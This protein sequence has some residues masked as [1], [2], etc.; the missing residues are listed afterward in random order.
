MSNETP[1]IMEYRAL[2]TELEATKA[3][4]AESRKQV[5]E[6]SEL[7]TLRECSVKIDQRVNRLYNRMNDLENKVIKNEEIVRRPSK[8]HPTYEDIIK[9]MDFIEQSFRPFMETA[10][11][12]INQ[13]MDGK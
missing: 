11:A 7:I 3:A 1:G 4:L 6:L 13:L 2:Q 9:R 8:L 12:Q 10:Q 5:K